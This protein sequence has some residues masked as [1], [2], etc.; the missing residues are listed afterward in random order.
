MNLYA[1]P[2]SNLLVTV[3][4]RVSASEC[5]C[6]VK[7]RKAICIKCI[8]ALRSQTP[9]YQ[10]RKPNTHTPASGILRIRH[11][12]QR[13]IPGNAAHL[14][15]CDANPFR[16]LQSRG[17]VTSAPR[18]PAATCPSPPR[19]ARNRARAVD[20]PAETTSFSGVEPS[21]SIASTARLVSSGG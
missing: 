5:Y 19:K 9:G 8:P 4:V 13:H 3:H 2:I 18:V 11:H 7:I 21:D 17:P 6:I 1:N 10:T 20:S 15:S 14:Q 16:S 12:F